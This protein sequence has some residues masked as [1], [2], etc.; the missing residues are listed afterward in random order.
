MSGKTRAVRAL[1]VDDKRDVAESFSRLLLTMGC[2][3]TWR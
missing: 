3:A 2:A 1:V